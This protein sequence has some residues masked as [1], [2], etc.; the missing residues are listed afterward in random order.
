MVGIFHEKPLG[1]GR[2]Q[3][4]IVGRDKD[5]RW[6]IGSGQDSVGGRSSGK[7]NGIVAAQSVI[8]G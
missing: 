8:L 1:A 4:V 2:R 5:E 7:V 3:Q 6:E